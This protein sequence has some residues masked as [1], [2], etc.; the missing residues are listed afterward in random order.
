MQRKHIN[1]FD[2]YFCI[3]LP[4]SEI[5]GKQVSKNYI[6]LDKVI[7][8]SFRRPVFAGNC[9]STRN[10]ARKVKTKHIIQENYKKIKWWWWYIL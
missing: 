3:L 6:L 4:Q 9:A 8:R 2:I 1:I 5:N 7:A 10:S